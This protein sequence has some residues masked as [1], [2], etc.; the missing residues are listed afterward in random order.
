MRV[1]KHPDATTVIYNIT[2]WEIRYDFTIGA[3]ADDPAETLN[4][5][6][7]ICRYGHRLLA[8]R[9]NAARLSCCS[10]AMT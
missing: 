6:D 3:L 10:V 5:S 9:L 7:E 4:L 1:L 2:L 8:L